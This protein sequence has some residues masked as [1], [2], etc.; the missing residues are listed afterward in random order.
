M[1]QDTGWKQNKPWAQDIQAR[2]CEFEGDDFGYATWCLNHCRVCGK[3]MDDYNRDLCERISAMARQ[4]QHKV[5]V[6]LPKYPIEYPGGKYRQIL[7]SKECDKEWLTQFYK[8]KVK[9]QSRQRE[10]G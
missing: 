6:D 10:R 9:K 8:P 1:A 7:C 2:L 3:A 4:K 5:I